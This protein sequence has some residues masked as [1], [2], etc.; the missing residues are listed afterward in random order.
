MFLGLLDVDMHRH[1]ARAIYQIL[2]AGSRHAAASRGN[3]IYTVRVQN[4]AWRNDG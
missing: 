3:S 1:G 2:L 4:H